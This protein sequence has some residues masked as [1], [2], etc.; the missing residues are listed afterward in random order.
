ML[1]RSSHVVITFEFLFAFLRQNVQQVI[2][3]RGLKILQNV[4]G[5]RFWNAMSVELCRKNVSGQKCRGRTV[6]RDCFGASFWDLLSGELWRKT[7]FD[8][9][10]GCKLIA[11]GLNDW[12]DVLCPNAWG[13]VMLTYFTYILTLLTLLT[14]LTVLTLLTLGLHPMDYPTFCPIFDEITNRFFW[15][16]YKPQTKTPWKTDGLSRLFGL[17]AYTSTNKIDLWFREKFDQKLD[18]P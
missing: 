10:L 15:W 2:E 8:I 3:L 13:W 4:H 5:E 11:E 7:F 18:N 1:G 12:T 6:M 14:L 17:V 16:W 9:T